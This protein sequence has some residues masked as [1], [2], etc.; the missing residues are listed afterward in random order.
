MGG[1]DAC[2]DGHSGEFAV[3]TFPAITAS[4]STLI[5]ASSDHIKHKLV[6]VRLFVLDTIEASTKIINMNILNA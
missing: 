2:V 6:D 1:V 4:G 5:E 3:V